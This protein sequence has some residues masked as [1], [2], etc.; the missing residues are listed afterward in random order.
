M[1]NLHMH[2]KLEVSSIGNGYSAWLKV[3]LWLSSLNAQLPCTAQTRG[4]IRYYYSDRAK[5]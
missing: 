2:K 4:R 3:L 5:R 1:L